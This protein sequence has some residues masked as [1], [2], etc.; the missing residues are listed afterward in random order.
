MERYLP[1]ALAATLCAA[2]SVG[3]IAAVGD[4]KPARTYAVVAAFGNQ[5]SFVQAMS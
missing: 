2:T 4:G 5:M 3:A 1:R